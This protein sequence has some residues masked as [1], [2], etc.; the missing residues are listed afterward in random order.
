[1]RPQSPANIAQ[2]EREKNRLISDIFEKHLTLGFMSE[3]EDPLSG[4]VLPV[5]SE[6]LTG[7]SRT[8]KEINIWLGHEK[9]ICL[10]KG[11][12]TSSERLATQFS[13]ALTMVHELCH[14]F[15]YAST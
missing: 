14:A 1:M 6:A 5:R 13:L 4:N 9:A 11:N 2:C 3:V 8:K 10:L 12:T 15:D 7:Y